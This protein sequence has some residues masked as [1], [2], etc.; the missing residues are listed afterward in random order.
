M[1]RGPILRAMWF[2]V[3]PSDIG[4][5][6]ISPFQ[7]VN[8]AIINASPERVFDIL[9][10]GENQSEWFQDFVENRWTSPE[11]Y[12]VGSTREVEL[13]II[14][15]KERFL[16][17]DRGKHLAFTITAS[18]VPAVRRMLEEF[19]MEPVGDRT[20]FRWTAH[21]TPSRLMRVVHPVMRI[22]FSKMFAVTTSKLAAY[23]G[24]SS[25]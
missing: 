15:V 22:Q 6:E 16:V 13:K 21:Y 5:T 9:A 4:Y 1:A 19:H 23:A 2:D 20:R 14:T 25:G 10:A 18:T 11:P 8:E 3:E 17:W 24:R 12:G 7:I